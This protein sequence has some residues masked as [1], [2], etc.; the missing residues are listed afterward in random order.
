MLSPPRQ[1]QRSSVTPRASP[2]AQLQKELPSTYKYKYLHHTHTAMHDNG[3]ANQADDR[4]STPGNS[5]AVRCNSD[6]P[7]WAW[8]AA[9]T[10]P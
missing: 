4:I 3:T 5:Q 7:A 8:G 2:R 1:S 6:S 10:L 9:S